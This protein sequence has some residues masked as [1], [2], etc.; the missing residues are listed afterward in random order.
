MN[1]RDRILDVAAESFLV[2]GYTNSRMLEIARRV[3][4]SRAALYKYF[5]D[6][7][8]VLLALND[9]VIKDAEAR[10]IPQLLKPGPAADRL[11]AWL[12]D[13]LRSQW[14]HNAVRVVTLEETQGVLAEDGVATQALLA[15]VGRAL[16]ST[17]RA[18]IRSGEFRADLKAK[19]EAYTIQSLV[20][21]LHRNNVSLRPILEIRLDK[22][23][24]TVIQILVGGLLR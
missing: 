23:I 10:G 24:E 19:D 20:L 4:V 1:T 21:G 22:H 6:K 13:N 17:I 16:E 14:R 3:G 2:E 18:G 11:G 12:E 5:P 15:K 8:A 9:R 7:R